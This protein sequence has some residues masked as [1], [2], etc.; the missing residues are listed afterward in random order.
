MYWAKELKWNRLVPRKGS[1]GITQKIENL[2]VTG[3]KSTC[4]IKPLDL[5]WQPVIRIKNKPHQL[6]LFHWIGL[7][8]VLNVQETQRIIYKNEL[9]KTDTRD[10]SFVNESVW[11]NDS[12]TWTNWPDST[13]HFSLVGSF[14]LTDESL[15]CSLFSYQ[16]SEEVHN[17]EVAAMCL[18]WTTVWR[19]PL[20]WSFGNEELRTLRYMIHR[21]TTSYRKRDWTNEQHERFRQELNLNIKQW[22]PPLR[23]TDP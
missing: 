13:F 3:Q 6:L 14:V 8:C 16:S 22:N 11:R 18:S 23:D 12:L 2:E 21:K 1:S 5:I 4:E 17:H 15:W 20:A 7:K 9:S 10:G 19:W